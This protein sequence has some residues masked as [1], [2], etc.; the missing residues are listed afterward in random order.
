VGAGE[1]AVELVDVPLRRFRLQPAK[2]VP[3]PVEPGILLQS[4]QSG[5]GQV[6][7][8]MMPLVVVPTGR[9]HQQMKVIG[10]RQPTGGELSEA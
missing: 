9:F 7:H 5:L 3:T 4:K 8:A 2:S 10:M 1:Q 6:P